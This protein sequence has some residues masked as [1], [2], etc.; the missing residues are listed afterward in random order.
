MTKETVKRLEELVTEVT[1]TIQMGNNAL[2]NKEQ[3][4]MLKSITSALRDIQE[5]N[6]KKY[7]SKK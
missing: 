5:Y 4:A 1:D 7:G 2:W 3:G 6:S